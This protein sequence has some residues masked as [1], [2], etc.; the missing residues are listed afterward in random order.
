[1]IKQR[2]TIFSLVQK[3]IAWLHEVAVSSCK[4]SLVYPSFEEVVF[5]IENDAVIQCCEWRVWLLLSHESSTQLSVLP[6]LPW[7][8]AHEHAVLLT[9]SYESMQVNNSDSLA[10]RQCNCCRHL[11]N[12]FQWREKTYIPLKHILAWISAQ[13]WQSFHAYKY[14]LPTTLAKLNYLQFLELHHLAEVCFQ[15]LMW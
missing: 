11:S 13:L 2:Q 8:H 6:P 3:P 7:L 14:L 10:T 15:N 12:K 5:M 4:Q 1:M 9:P